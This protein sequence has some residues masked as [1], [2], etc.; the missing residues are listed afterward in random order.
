MSWL[1][2]QEPAEGF[3][4]ENSLDGKPCARSKSNRTAKR[5][6]I[7]G[8]KADRMRERQLMGCHSASRGGR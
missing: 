5:Y 6:F 1:Y 4:E 7:G 3:L 8:A 2:L